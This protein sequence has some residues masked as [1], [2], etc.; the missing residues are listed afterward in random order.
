M[1]SSSRPY[2]PKT[3]KCCMSFSSYV[4]SAI[5]LRAKAQSC[6]GCTSTGNVQRVAHAR[7]ATSEALRERSKKRTSSARARM[8]RRAKLREQ[9]KRGTASRKEGSGLAG[10]RALFVEPPVF[11]FLRRPNFGRSSRPASVDA[12]FSSRDAALRATTP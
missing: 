11:T 1:A 5:E 2:P 8:R 6:A 12:S 7:E 3:G 10:W 4:A 9:P